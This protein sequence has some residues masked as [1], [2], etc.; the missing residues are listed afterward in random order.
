MRP[1][2][3]KAEFVGLFLLLWEPEQAK[4][5][6]TCKQVPGQKTKSW[7]KMLLTPGP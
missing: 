6:A 7:E 4:P 1:G 2:D 5:A 3:A